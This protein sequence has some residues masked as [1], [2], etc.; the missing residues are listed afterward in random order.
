[1]DEL[2]HL[3]PW[4]QKHQISLE[5]LYI[6]S[7]HNIADPAPRRHDADLWSLKPRKQIFLLQQVHQRLGHPVDTNPFA[8]QQLAVPTHYCTP[9]HDRHSAGFNGLLLDWSTPH[10]VYL[11]P[12]WNILPQVLLKMKASGAKGVAVYPQWPLQTWHAELEACSKAIFHLPS[13]Y[14]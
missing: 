14:T 2:Y 4:L 9:L 1:M 6:R 7:E 11:N 5:V 3:V 8:C 10:V 13:P 12:P